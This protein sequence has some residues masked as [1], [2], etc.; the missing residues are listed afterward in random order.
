M[1]QTF[2]QSSHDISQC[3]Y[4]YYTFKNLL[5]IVKLEYLGISGK[6]MFSNLFTAFSVLLTIDFVW[7]DAF[8]LSIIHTSDVKARIEPFD[9][10]GGRCAQPNFKG[11]YGGVARQV[12]LVGS[13]YALV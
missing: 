6:P 5:R 13:A 12:T 2:E 4:Y 10:R 1:A 3:I 8:T 9:T 11:C 7:C